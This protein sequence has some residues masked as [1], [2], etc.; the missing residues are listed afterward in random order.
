MN[1]WVNLSSPSLTL[2]FALNIFGANPAHC[3]GKPVKRGELNLRSLVA[4]EFVTRPSLRG[5]PTI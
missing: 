3:R 5:R 4:A 2:R 1:I